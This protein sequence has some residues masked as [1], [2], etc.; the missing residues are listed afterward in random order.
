M[1]GKAPSIPSQGSFTRRKNKSI[2]FKACSDLST[3][4]FP[5]MCM[6]K[7]LTDLQAH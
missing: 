5:G 3:K 6:G 7:M 1:S 4:T 2:F